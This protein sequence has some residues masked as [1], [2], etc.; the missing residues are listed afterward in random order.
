MG[1]G[2]LDT[3]GTILLINK[4]GA[5]KLHGKPEDFVGRS[6]TDLTNHEFAETLLERITIAANSKDS[7]VYEDHIKLPKPEKWYIFTFTRIENS[8]GEIT[9]VQIVANDI[10]TV[11]KAQR[12]RDR[13]FNLSSNLLCVTDFNG[14]FKQLNHNWEE[15]LGWSETELKSK[16]IQEFMHPQD[17]SKKPDFNEYARGTDSNIKFE[18]RFKTKHGNYKWLSWNVSILPSEGIVFADVRDVTNQKLSEE[19][20]LMSEKSTEHC[21]NMIQITRSYLTKTESSWM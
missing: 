15:L 13:F 3:N 21:S 14:C 1:I 5:Q 2:Y 19:A 6:I 9:G 17:R 10:T 8:E 12:E 11:K 7:M 20:L 18:N 16:P 4:I